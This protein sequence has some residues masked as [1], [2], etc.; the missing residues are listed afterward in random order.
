MITVLLSAVLC[1]AAVFLI[2]R[3]T[4]AILAPDAHGPLASAWRILID[5]LT[6]LYLWAIVPGQQ[7]G[8]PVS[9]PVREFPGGDM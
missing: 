7:P 5:P 2:F 4:A 3:L 9:L 6:G 8:W 1:A